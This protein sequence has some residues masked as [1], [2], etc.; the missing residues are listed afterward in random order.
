[1]W[2]RKKSSVQVPGMHLEWIRKD[3]ITKP[4]RHTGRFINN[5][6]KAANAIKAEESSEVN[7]LIIMLEINELC[8]LKD[9]AAFN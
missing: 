6:L 3:L 8:S 4:V 5:V 7:I 2:K 9:F 1:M